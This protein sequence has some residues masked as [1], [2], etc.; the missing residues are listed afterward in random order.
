M[1]NQSKSNHVFLPH[2]CMEAL[3]QINHHTTSAVSKM[4][5]VSIQ[6]LKLH[7]K[8]D[9]FGRTSSP[10]LTVSSFLSWILSNWPFHLQ[11]KVNKVTKQCNRNDDTT[12][13]I[14]TTNVIMTMRII[15]LINAMTKENCTYL[16]QC[17]QGLEKI[18]LPTGGTEI[19]DIKVVKSVPW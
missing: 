14:I 2:W 6:K 15:T 13:I 3:K 1:V 9:N 8:V 11:R 7:Q 16:C 4:L 19:S 18:C 17:R 12:T 5:K 10:M